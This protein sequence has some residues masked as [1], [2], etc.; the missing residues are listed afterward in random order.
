MLKFRYMSYL[1]L[2]VGAVLLFSFC[3]SRTTTMPYRFIDHYKPTANMV[4]SRE[5]VQE[6]ASYEFNEEGNT[7]GWQPGLG[8]KKFQVR[9][10]KLYIEAEANAPSSIIKTNL[11]AKQVTAVRI[12]MKN[13]AGNMGS[14][15][16]SLE[17]KAPLSSGNRKKF[18]IIS[19]N[20]FHDY[21]I[22]VEDSPRWKRTIRRILIRPS[23]TQGSAEIDSIAFLYI[24]YGER[25]LLESIDNGVFK[26]YIGDQLRRIIFAAP[27]F[28]VE[29]TIRFPRDAFF[30]FGYGII[31]KAWFKEGDGVQFTVKAVDKDGKSYNLFSDYIDPKNNKNDRKWFDARIDLSQFAGQTIKIVLETEGSKKDEKLSHK[32]SDT[33][34]D[35]AVW[36]SPVLYRAKEKKVQ[37]NIIL[38]SLDSLRADS[39]GCCGYWRKTSPTIDKLVKNNHTVK[40]TRAFASST[41]TVP[42]HANLFTGKHLSISSTH[43]IAYLNRRENT[44]AEELRQV[45]YD[46]VA[47]T[48]G[49]FMHHALGFD[50]G[51]DSYIELI[52]TDKN[53]I[54]ETYNKIANWLENKRTDKFFL[55]IHSYETHVPYGRTYFIKSLSRGNIPEEY[56]RRFPI[57]YETVKDL[58]F[59]A[60]EEER[61]YIRA[62]YD[63]GI[64]EADKYLGLLFDKL[65]QLDLWENTIIIITSDHGEAF[66]EHHPIGAMHGHS[67]YNEVIHVPL[68]I[69]APKTRIKNNT[70]ENNVSHVD[71]LASIL[72]LAGVKGFNKSK[73][74]GVSL[75]PLMKGKTYDAER[76]IFSEL[77][78]QSSNIRLQSIIWNNYKYIRSL[79]GKHQAEFYGVNLNIAEEELFNINSDFNETSNIIEQNPELAKMARTKLESFLYQNMKL[80]LSGETKAEQVLDEE[81]KRRLKALGYLK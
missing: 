25:L 6:V 2:V 29:H 40:F 7:E 33:R 58:I 10:G 16:W 1:L 54:K 55:F 45:E 74:M 15:F 19:D 68:I 30:D 31:P 63:G 41:R 50:K 46:T 67:L 27:P 53:R 66:W 12:R 61:R 9:A 37:P 42:S 8:V 23:T 32:P 20:N 51:F 17:E 62:L 72:E 59:T 22:F 80:L 21:Y 43:E 52:S 44:L 36:S 70:I 76:I 13:S 47:F 73:L 39:L 26:G 64:R 28:K 49:G 38:I 14:L 11:L 71:I 69:Y 35:Y 34:Y 75:V 65:K 77:K 48:D 79:N 56:S 57:T 3:Q 18:T 78:D 81:L 60:T 4:K 5:K 24:P